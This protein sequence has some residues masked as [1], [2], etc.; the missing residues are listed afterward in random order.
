MDALLLYGAPH[1]AAVE[2][3][4]DVGE[5]G[6]VA[7]CC[8]SRVRPRMEHTAQSHSVHRKRCSQLGHQVAEGH[9]LLL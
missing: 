2:Q 3:D 1:E 6:G 4:S 8:W 5:R 9:V 7:L